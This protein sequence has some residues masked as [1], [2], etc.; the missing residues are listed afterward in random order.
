MIRQSRT[1]LGES[2]GTHQFKWSISDKNQHGKELL[3]ACVDIKN[4]ERPMIADR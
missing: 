4:N 1:K 3:A 2:T